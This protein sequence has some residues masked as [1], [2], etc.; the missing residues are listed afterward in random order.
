MLAENSR[1]TRASS[2]ASLKPDFSEVRASRSFEGDDGLTFGT[3]AEADTAAKTSLVADAQS[4]ATLR[5]AAAATDIA[6]ETVRDIAGQVAGQIAGPMVEFFD[7]LSRR[8]AGTLRLR[9]HPDDLGRVDVQITRDD[10]GRLNAQFTAE[11]EATRKILNDDISL[12]RE[13]LERAGISVERLDVGVDVH[14]NSGSSAGNQRQFQD[15]AQPP[16]GAPAAPLTAHATLD[17]QPAAGS[18]DRIISIRA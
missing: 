5:N 11:H 8:E 18:D 9:L 15:F 4:T 6:R 13:T 1:L 7:K 17:G 12:L 3:A 2:V 10:A 14:T 16:S